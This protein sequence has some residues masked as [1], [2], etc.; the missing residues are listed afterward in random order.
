MIQYSVGANF[1]LFVTNWLW[2]SGKMKGYPDDIWTVR[3]WTVKFPGDIW[4]VEIWTVRISTVKTGLGLGLGFLLWLGLGL[5]LGF[6]LVFGLGL[7]LGLVMTVQIL[8]VMIKIGNHGSRCY[9]I[10]R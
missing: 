10:W 3:I 5:M 2:N 7:G 4:T 8:T 6:E 1:V 9:L